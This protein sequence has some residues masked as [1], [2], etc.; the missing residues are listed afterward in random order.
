[1]GIVAETGTGI[2]RVTCTHDCPDACAML[3][4][5]RDGR[6]VDVAPNPAHPVTGR[7]L[8][9][10]VDRYL[11]RVYSPD[12]LLHPLRRTGV[13]GDGRFARISW[14]EAIDEIA[15]RWRSIIVAD[16][17]AAI[18]PYSYLG[19]MGTLATFGTT[20]ALFHRLG[21][22]RLERTICGGQNVGLT[23]LVGP[24]WTDPEH[25]VDARLI[26]VWGMDPISTSVHTWSLIRRARERGARLVV[27]D[28]Y[29]SR[30]STQADLHIRIL[31]GTDGAL[32]L[33]IL[34]IILRDGLDDQDYIAR[35]TTGLAA[36]R[37]SVAP[38]TPEAT[39]GA[40]GLA[41]DD[42]VALAREYATTRPACIRH[43]VG[44]QRAAGAGMALR[45]LQ[46]LPVVTGQWRHHAGG[47]AD[48]RTI[49]AVAIGNLMRLDLG[50]SP[51]RTFNMIQLGRHL[52]DPA[53]RPPIRSLYVWASNPAVITADQARV[54]EGLARADL[55]TVVH[56]QFMTDTARYADIVL[57]APTMLE[58]EDLVGSWGFNY[59]A[60]SEQAIAPLG[61]ARSNSE[62]TRLLA[63]R[64]GFDEPV[65]RMTDRELIALAVRGSRA[66]ADGATL[67][68]LHA[69]GFVRVGL[70][71]GR[72]PFAEGGFPTS[73][74]KFE[75]ESADLAKAGLG[76]LPVYVPPAESPETR[77][78][79]ATR[80]PLRLLTLKRHHSINSSYG[81]LPVLLH[82]EPE[83]CLEI[84]PDDASARGIK[85]GKPVRVWNERGTVTYRARV[86]D[87]VLPG[88]VAAPFGNWMHDGAS[89]NALTSDRL[90]DIGNGPTFCDTLVEIAVC[91]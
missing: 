48:A 77:P 34:N 79:L 64:L 91:E 16:G 61:E 75:F 81:G 29:R 52:T 28:P 32:A 54:L 56:E 33:G 27:I 78:D 25:L 67:E 68:R 41:A 53:L 46:C 71:R 73:S 19:S 70:P 69:E 63:A 11:E 7:H 20:H 88:M 85:D 35:H 59:V 24:T 18:L 14:D 76:P 8:C 44:M 51:S 42:V 38:W 82:A 57:P 1:L 37:E 43:G 22:S 47:I 31:P 10:K 21:A 55:F 87:R 45:A 86:T 74:G 89:V 80:F 58:Q 6:A 62:V 13:K 23:G 90:G 5:V 36:L 84:H 30:T 40:T 3:I 15:V 49:R 9:V 12:R 60:L 39:A 66:E 2:A 50:D 65:F 4:T 72:A 83:P 17:A 26:L